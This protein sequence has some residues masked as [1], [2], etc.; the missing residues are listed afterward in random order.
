MSLSETG[1]WL[2]KWIIPSE[3]WLPSV[4]TNFL[5]EEF[6]QLSLNSHVMDLEHL[7]QT[8]WCPGKATT[9]R[10]FPLAYNEFLLWSLA[11]L[12]SGSWNCFLFLRLFWGDFVCFSWRTGFRSEVWL[13]TLIWG[14]WWIFCL[15]KFSNCLKREALQIAVELIQLLRPFKRIWLIPENGA[16]CSCW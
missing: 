11:P 15:I 9:K 3:M 13:V 16:S 10:M 8:E 5:L 4:K 12:K 6:S 1:A 2:H 14:V 7:E